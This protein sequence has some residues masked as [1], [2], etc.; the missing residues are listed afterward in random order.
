MQKE[1]IIQF[2]SFETTGDTAEFISQWDQYAKEMNDNHE[3]RLH[4]EMGS[5]KKSRYLSRHK[6]F[7]D[8]FKFIFKRERR[9]AHFP[10]VEMRVRQLG[11]YTIVQLQRDHDVDTDENK[12]FVFINRSAI[13]L[14]EYRQLTNYRYLNIYMAYF[15]SS[16]H[17][18]ILE[19][20]ANKNSETE[21]LEQLKSIGHHF[22]L[23]MY[24][25]CLLQGV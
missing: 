5:K 24:K 25:E 6:C 23:G 3:I 1:P 10:E 22:E 14:D 12:L 16:V 7:D 21:L 11:G 17:E 15:E 20:F 4:Q 18:Y 19:F 2:V 8:E 9:S 13:D